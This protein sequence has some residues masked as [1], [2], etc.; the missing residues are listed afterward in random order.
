[1]SDRGVKFYSSR[2]LSCGNNLSKAEII[3]ETYDEKHEYS[4][5]NT[6]LEFYNIK[7]YLEHQCY[8]KKWEEKTINKYRK[9]SQSF[10]KQIGFYLSSINDGNILSIYR[11]IKSQY[12]DDF[13]TLFEKF[14]LYNKIS[15]EVFEILLTERLNLRYVLNHRILVK[16]Y[17]EIISKIMKTH[18]CS[19]E[20][21]L[22]EYFSL[23][24]I[25]KKYYFPTSLDKEELVNMYIDSK[26][27]NL[28]YI[29]L[30]FKSTSTN[31]FIL[32][33]K[34]RLKAKRRYDQ[35]INNFFE[36]GTY[37]KYGVNLMFSDTQKRPVDFK[38]ENNNLYYTYSLTWFKNNLNYPI[39]LIYNFIHIFAYVDH[40]IRFLHVR[41]TNLMS[42]M[43][44]LLGIKGK[45][46]YVTDITFEILNKA[47]QLQMIAY[48][49][50]L[51]N[52]N[53][54]LEEVYKWFFEEYIKKEFNVKGFYFNSPSKNATYLEKNRTLNSE[55]DSILKQFRMWCEDKKIDLE[56]LQMSSSHTFFK[57]IPSL[58][59]KK[60]IY[61]NSEEFDMAGYLLC[62]DQSSIHY[63]SEIYNQS[64]F[65]D[66]IEKNNLKINDFH[67]YQIDS[68]QWLI[69][70]HYIYENEDGFLKNSLDAVWIVNELY[71]N[72]VLSYHHL[73]QSKRKMVDIFLEKEIL[74]Y[75]NTLFSKPE[76][77]Y[78]NY[79]FNKS[80]FSNGLDLRNKY[81]HGTQ[82]L[83]IEDQK[84]DYYIILR[85]LVLC[86]LKINDEF[87]LEYEIEVFSKK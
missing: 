64:K 50:F 44:D 20:I 22:E 13:W 69:D 12:Y 79:I 49:N 36:K 26:K 14:K 21:L 75:E 9:I 87:C 28:N 59:E 48:Y 34:M 70:H 56:L 10:N 62:S 18:I 60:Y 82:S 55:I 63:I 47:A 24:K 27:A 52:E 51:L 57:D 77:D 71:F 86:I 72:D 3:L 4:D 43:Y 17:D 25:D 78:L 84:N 37:L 81:I 8:L 19:C 74:K 11:E 16:K 67:E 46:E 80:S 38:F 68:I 35:G 5:I 29:E 54:V 2:D 30:I 76:Y 45:Y 6:I 7:L 83:N 65:C 53:I 1:M 73:A 23:K 15:K 40:Q 85:M 58:I 39:V 32:T 33:D 31:D 66:L 61:S 41:K 42:L